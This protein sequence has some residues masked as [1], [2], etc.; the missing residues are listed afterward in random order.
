MT[1]SSKSVGQDWTEVFPAGAIHNGRVLADRI[2][3]GG[4]DFDP[5]RISDSGDWRDLRRCFECL[6][7]W[8]ENHPSPPPSPSID[9]EV[10][11]Q[12]VEALKVS[13]RLIDEALPKFDWG[14]SALDADAI[15]LLNEVPVIVDAALSL[16]G[17]VR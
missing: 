14:N 5:G 1:D 4:F 15:R 2:E 10:H 9:P 3:A 12:V 16:A 13:K 7:E 11:R 8:A 17:E 6:V